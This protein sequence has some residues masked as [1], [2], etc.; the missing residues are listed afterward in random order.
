MDAVRRQLAQP[1][2]EDRHISDRCV[3]GADDGDAVGRPGVGRADTDDRWVDDPHVRST[4]DESIAVGSHPDLAGRLESKCDPA[5]DDERRSTRPH[6]VDHELTPLADVIELQLEVVGGRLLAICLAWHERSSQSSA[7]HAQRGAHRN[8]NG[9]PPT[10]QGM[11]VRRL[12][13]H[14]TVSTPD[15]NICAFNIHVQCR[16]GI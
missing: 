7:G 5:T 14:I 4:N 10:V 2:T 12:V 6:P 8:S 15:I 13:H 3:A 9:T 1:T 16:I 11:V